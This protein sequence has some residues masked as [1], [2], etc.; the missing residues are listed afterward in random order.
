[1]TLIAAMCCD[2]GVVIASDSKATE[3]STG[4]LLQDQSFVAKKLFSLG[5]KIVW[6]SSGSGGV[7]QRLGLAFAN[8]YKS[9]SGKYAKAA[10][11]VH[12]HCRGI[13]TKVI[14]EEI[15]AL[16][17]PLTIALQMGSFVPNSFLFAGFDTKPWIQEILW[18][19]QSTTYADVGFHAI[20][21]GGLA[22]LTCYKLL[23]HHELKGAPMETVRT[24]LY[25]I[26]DVCIKSSSGG[27]GPPIKM[28]EITASGSEELTVEQLRATEDTVGVWESEER[29][30]L[31]GLPGA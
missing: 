14:K 6:G 8:D 29:D 28:W 5:P 13:I 3:G 17:M 12:S 9:S 21:S 30:C 18:D 26:T 4:N 16:P 31:R 1:M 27:L 19:G 2:S 15:N 23:E 10:A 24:V 7:A 20:G 11:E 22:A 25:R